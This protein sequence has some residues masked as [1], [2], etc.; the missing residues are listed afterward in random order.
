LDASVPHVA[1][2]IRR[3]LRGR[4]NEAE[5]KEDCKEEKHQEQASASARLVRSFEYYVD[6]EKIECIQKEELKE[7]EMGGSNIS[8]MRKN[9]LGES[10]QI[11]MKEIS[12]AGDSSQQNGD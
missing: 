12:G 5:P 7:E 8:P 3:E 10:S 1:I 9:K 4:A 6:Y 2:H 11:E